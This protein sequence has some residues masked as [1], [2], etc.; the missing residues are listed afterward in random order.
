MNQLLAI[1][2]AAAV[3]S[4]LA[5]SADT[6][7]Y[8]KGHVS[9]AKTSDEDGLSVNSH[10]S[11]I[12][13]KGSNA[14]DNGLSATHKFEFGY[15]ISDDSNGLTDRDAWIGLKGGFGEVR[16]GR[17]TTP[18][19]IVDDATTFVSRNDHALHSFQRNNNTLAYINKFGNVGL[20]AA[21]ISEAEAE[22]GEGADGIVD[23]MVNYLAG[24]LYAGAAITKATDGDAGTKVAL[25]Y[26]GPNYGVGLNV[27]N[28][29]LWVGDCGE[30]NTVVT[31]GGKYSFGKAY[32]AG[33]FGQDSDNAAGERQ[34]LN[35]EVGYGLGKGTKIYYE[36]ESIDN[37]V[38]KTDATQGTEQVNSNRI[39]LV[40]DF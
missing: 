7:V 22:G 19:S 34:Q 31:V 32:L 38:D 37:D 20:A 14:L 18:Y 29:P 25:A 9:V 6:K 35:F 33:Q 8:G 1:A 5:V 39:G 28:C 21:Y 11:R 15:N 36:Y 4:P 40:H 26:N 3:F 23:A 2:V 16:V 27:E 24:P 12:G 17:H 10:S 30:G 13:L